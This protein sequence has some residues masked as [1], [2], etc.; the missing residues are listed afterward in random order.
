[1]D[2]CFNEVCPNT[3][4]TLPFLQEQS[5][6]LAFVL[7]KGIL[8]VVF[9]ISAALIF[10]SHVRGTCFLQSGKHTLIQTIY[11]SDSKQWSSPNWGRERNKLDGDKVLNYTGIP[12]VF[13]KPQSHPS[14]SDFSWL[15]AQKGRKSLTML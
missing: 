2:D 6:E 10:M 12:E 4:R 3:P 8:C 9:C 5:C 1:M 7:P 15:G 11:K 13:A 14:T